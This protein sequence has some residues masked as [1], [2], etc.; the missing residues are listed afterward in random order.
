MTHAPIIKPYDK[1]T[2]SGKK[3]RHGRQV[4]YLQAMVPYLDEIIDYHD[5][6]G[7]TYLEIKKMMKGRTDE[8]KRLRNI[9]LNVDAQVDPESLFMSFLVAKAKLGSFYGWSDDSQD[10]ENLNHIYKTRQEDGKRY[11]QLTEKI[12][13]LIKE[14]Q[15]A[16]AEK[17]RRAREKVGSSLDYCRAMMLATIKHCAELIK[18][19]KIDIKEDDWEE[20]RTAILKE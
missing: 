11:F 20:A 10:M 5:K 13:Q 15:D 6:E 8:L 17:V 16:E 2:T 9:D 12:Q 3:N 4:F 19:K 7:H 1:I 18:K 14:S